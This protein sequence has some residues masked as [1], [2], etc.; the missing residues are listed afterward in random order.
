MIFVPT[1]LLLLIGFFF[2]FIGVEGLNSKRKKEALFLLLIGFAQIVC[3]VWLYNLT[4]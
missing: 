4:M 1:V 3:L 2:L